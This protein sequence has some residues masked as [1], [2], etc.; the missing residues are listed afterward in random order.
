MKYLISIIFASI[1][2]SVDVMSVVL[3]S[4]AKDLSCSGYGIASDGAY[5]INPALLSHNK[6]T[7]FEFSNNN[8]LF[9]VAGS[10]LS[11]TDKDIRLSGHY[12]QVD[13]I[14]MYDNNPS[15]SPVSTFGSKTLFLNVAQGF[16]I[17]NSNIGYSLKYTY[18]KLLE[19][20]DKG[21][22]LDFGYQR[23]FGESVSVGF[24]IKNLNSGFKNENQIPVTSVIGTSQKIK[25]LP[26]TLNFDLIY[27]SS[28]DVL[29][30][31]QGIVFDSKVANF[32]AGCRYNY[33]LEELD[34][35][36]GV[37]LFWKNLEFSISYLIKDNNDIGNP[38]FYQLSYQL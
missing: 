19:Y 1:S 20:E 15:E 30:S 9:D 16:E 17:N 36:F 23:Q 34:T 11:Y 29:G 12:W 27:N 28:D 37:S 21:F 3:P 14:E 25:S 10:Y 4:S 31:Y 13:D 24:M 33:S 18:M 22:V 35:S 5:S 7:Y 32:T 38:T 6:R 2:L 26:I 8:W